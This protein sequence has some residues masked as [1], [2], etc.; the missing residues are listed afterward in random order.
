MTSFI[1][2]AAIAAAALICALLSAILLCAREIERLLE[3]ILDN[4]FESAADTPF[5]EEEGGALEQRRW[6]EGVKNLLSYMG[7]EKGGDLR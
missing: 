6:E 2:I 1:I 5:E 4:S 3:T 7:A